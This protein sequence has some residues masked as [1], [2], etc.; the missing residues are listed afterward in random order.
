M[1]TTI[2]NIDELLSHIEYPDEYFFREPVQGGEP[3]YFGIAEGYAG[4]AGTANAAAVIGAPVII[5]QFNDN[6]TIITMIEGRETE[7]G[8][9]A[10]LDSMAI[11]LVKKHVV[12]GA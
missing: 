9:C 6:R 8:Y 2:T 11:S 12:F 1:L 7:N 3:M 5:A 4:L 10:K